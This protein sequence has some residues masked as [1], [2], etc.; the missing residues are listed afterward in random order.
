MVE[1]LKYGTGPTK[2]IF[3]HGWFGDVHDFDAVFSGI[4]PDLFSIACVEFRGY[5]VAKD[6]SGPF[7]VDRIAQDALALADELG[8]ERFSVVGHSMGGKV[9]IK[10]VTIAPERVEKL[11]GIAPVWAGRSPFDEERLSM[12]RRAPQV[13]AVRE[14]VIHGTTGGRLP[15]FWS[16]TLAAKS[17]AICKPEALGDY[18]E[19]WALGDFSGEVAGLD[20][21][22]LVVIGAYDPGL[23]EAAMK[24]TWLANLP[25]ARLIIMPDAGHYP[26]AETPIALAAHITTFLAAQA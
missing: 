4:D 7:D 1:H 13:L 6:Q 12:L 18:F 9:A 23:S 26:I 17:G 20:I 15:A 21:E 5:G 24:A 22:T 19:S 3:I 10:V 16:R 11:C 2:A 14:G 8:W 25:N